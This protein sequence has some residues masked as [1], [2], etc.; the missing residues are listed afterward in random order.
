MFDTDEDDEDTTPIDVGAALRQV[1]QPAV[2]PYWPGFWLN[3]V[4]NFVTGPFLVFWPCTQAGILPATI[5][6][7]L[8]VVA[9]AVFTRLC[10]LD[11]GLAKLPY[12]R[13]DQPTGDNND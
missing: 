7:Y 10:I 11:T 6:G 8:S 9:V 4:M 1:L 13:I 2:E 3:V 12:I 5:S